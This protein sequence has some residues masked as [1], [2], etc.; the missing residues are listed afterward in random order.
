MKSPR[1]PQSPPQSIYIIGAQST[2]KTTLVHALEDHF[3]QLSSPPAVI[4]EVARALLRQRGTVN[5]S[6]RTRHSGCYTVDDIRA[7]PTRS[8]DLQRRI[9][10]GQARAEHDVVKSSKHGSQHW[11]VSDRSALDPV[12][13]AW[14]Y[15]GPGAA[16]GLMT[17]EWRRMR[18]RMAGSL[19]VLCEAGVDWLTDDGLR[20]MPTSSEEWYRTHEVFCQVLKE[21]RLSYVVLPRSVST[22]EERMAFVLRSWRSYI[23]EK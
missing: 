11:L 20:L 17:P 8:L 9:L 7:S 18:D 5:S 10:A 3:S 2:G 22:T 21:A 19:I 13:Y 16:R 12:A 1:R 15:V 14:Q 6:D 23:P 4:H